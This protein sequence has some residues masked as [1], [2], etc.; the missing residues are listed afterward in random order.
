MVGGRTA[1][2]FGGVGKGSK[3]E[4][5]CITTQ[6]IATRLGDWIRGVVVLDASMRLQ[7]GKFWIAPGR[8]RN[9]MGSRGVGGERETLNCG[10]VVHLKLAPP[11]LMGL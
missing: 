8:E 11:P 10:N 5:I 3:S 2:R 9:S 1:L 4:H 6:G 7:G